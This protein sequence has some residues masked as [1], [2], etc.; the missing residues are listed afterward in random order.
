MSKKEIDSPRADV[1]KTSTGQ[2][3]QSLSHLDSACRSKGQSQRGL[4]RWHSPRGLWWQ[5]SP[6][7][8]G[9]GM[10][11]LTQQGT[12]STPPADRRPFAVF[13]HLTLARS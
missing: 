10:Q 5:E 9:V 1:D 2:V 3:S 8:G 11:H 7:A 6:R 12:E 4:G 13:T